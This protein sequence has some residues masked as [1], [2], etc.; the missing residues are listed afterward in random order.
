MSLY[1]NL[2]TETLSQLNLRK[3][4]LVKPTL[5]LR[6]AIIAMR[7]SN[8]GCAVVID[9]E[10]RPIGMFT[11][12]KL[13]ELLAN[14]SVSIDEPVGLHSNEWFSHLPETAPIISLLHHLEVKNTRFLAV[15]DEAGRVSG[16]TGQKGL[17]E[18]IAEHFPGQVMVQRVGQKPFTHHREGA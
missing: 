4:V 8:L 15:T 3:P 14:T 1:H 7:K 10:E 2:K 17:M 6:D 13:T 11:E 16:L 9:D 5:P 12:R 18:Y